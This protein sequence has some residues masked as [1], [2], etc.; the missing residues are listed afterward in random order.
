LRFERTRRRKIVRNRAADQQ[1][2]L[3]LA[4]RRLAPVF[5]ECR[6]GGFDLGLRALQIELRGRATLDPARHHVIAFLLRLQR[7]LR[8][9]HQ[10]LIRLPRQIRVRDFGNQ[11]DLRTGACLPAQSRNTVATPDP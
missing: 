4:L 6:I 2:Q 9:R 7:R 1:R 8:Q 5:V 3:V 10:F 11:R